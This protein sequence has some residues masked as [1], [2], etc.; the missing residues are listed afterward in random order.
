MTL[1][2]FGV[3]RKGKP[4]ESK[5]STDGSKTD[6]VPSKVRILLLLEW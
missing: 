1:L 6:E 2:I 4:G 3:N 5:S